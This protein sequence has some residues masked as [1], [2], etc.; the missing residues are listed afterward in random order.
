MLTFP[1]E[2]FCKT[3]EIPSQVPQVKLSMPAPEDPYSTDIIK[4]LD[5]FNI[6]DQSQDAWWMK[7]WYTKQEIKRV[8]VSGVLT[9]VRYSA[10]LLI[11]T[12]SQTIFHVDISQL[13]PNQAGAAYMTDSQDMPPSR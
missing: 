1:W 4:K 6:G 5:S 11:R 8:V 2:I 12:V 3:G 13:L 10:C 7:Y 9:L